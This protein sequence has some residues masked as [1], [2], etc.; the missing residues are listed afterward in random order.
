MLNT[1]T[2]ISTYD[3]NN[4]YPQLGANRYYDC[5]KLTAALF[6]YYQISSYQLID[7]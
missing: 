3:L 6:S 4:F 2:F 1:L 5:E 7:L